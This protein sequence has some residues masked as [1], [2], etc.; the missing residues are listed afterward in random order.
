MSDLLI[1]QALETRLAALV[2]ALETAH[3][4]MKFT[5]KDG[6]PYQRVDFLPAEPEN[7]TIDDFRRFLGVMQVTLLYPIGGGVGTAME[8]A[9][10]IRAHFPRRLSLS[11]GGIVVTIHRT[12]YIMPGFRDVRD[13]NR[14]AVPVRVPYFS[15]V[16]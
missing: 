1:R 6:T 5:P 11:S 4:N 10:A 12:P 16:S 8:R 15:N 7:P 13:E 14:W 3:E 2:P 9:E